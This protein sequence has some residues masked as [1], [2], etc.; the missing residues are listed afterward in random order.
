VNA[1]SQ[2]IVVHALDLNRGRSTAL[3]GNGELL[4]HLRIIQR[5]IPYG[6]SL[7]LGN[8]A[9]EIQSDAGKFANSRIAR[10]GTGADGIAQCPLFGDERTLTGCNA[11]S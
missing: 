2:Q 4:R 3:R 8:A 5:L 7:A 11:T 6:V 1:N 9:I 10:A